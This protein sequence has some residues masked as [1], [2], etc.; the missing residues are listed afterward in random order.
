MRRLVF[1]KQNWEAV[2]CVAHENGVRMTHYLKMKG[3]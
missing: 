3:F 2:L 1:A